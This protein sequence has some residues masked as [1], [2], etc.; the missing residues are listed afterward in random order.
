MLFNYYA[1]KTSLTKKRLESLQPILKKQQQLLVELTTKISKLEE[2]I[3]A[4][5]ES[6]STIGTFIKS[7][8]KNSLLVEEQRHGKIVI[9]LEN[10][11]KSKNILS[12]KTQLTPNTISISNLKKGDRLA[13]RND[14]YSAH[15]LLPQDIDPMVS[16]MVVENINVSYS[17]VGGLEEQIKEIREVIELP[18]RRPE[19]FE[20]LGIKPP[21]GVLLY[22]PP[23]T[24]KTLLAKAVASQSGCKF[25]K[26]SGSELVQ[27]YIGEGSR[28][29]REIFSVARRTAPC[30]VFIDE[31]DA[32]GA[33]R[34]ESAGG[35]NEVQR[36][37]LELLSQLDGFTE[38][39]NVKVIMATNRIDILDPALLR[40]GRL[41]RKIELPNPSPKSIEKIFTIHSKKM[42]C[43]RNVDIKK[44]C[45]LMKDSSGADIK[46][47]CTEAGMNAIRENRSYVVMNDFENAVSKV[48]KKFKSK[49]IQSVK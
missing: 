40:P 30:V 31:V 8:G 48:M 25:L 1:D 16:L 3:P 22:G 27:K 49:N 17:E 46:G 45:K 36:T 21:K 38:N 35:E 2:E 33:V 43:G 5:N 12:R 29:I 15:K 13:L 44:I 47:I 4:I 41:D 7:M 14:T 11:K 26:V 19:L 18:L 20:T 39:L 24:G 28:L 34:T 32:I 37:M 10:K 9:N 42:N 23:G 6:P